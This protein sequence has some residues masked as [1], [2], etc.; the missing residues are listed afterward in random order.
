MKDLAPEVSECVAIVMIKESFL[1]YFIKDNLII[2]VL[3]RFFIVEFNCG[4]TTS[5]NSTYFANPQSPQRI[6]NLMINRLNNEICQVSIIMRQ[7]FFG[8]H[9][10][11]TFFHF[12][13]QIRID[14]E[15]FDISPPDF[16]GQCSTDFFLV[17]GGSPVPTLCGTNTGQHGD[18]QLFN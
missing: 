4:R 13:L 9:G 17:T 15:T 18:N 7:I 11:M 6:C 8:V 14:F 2:S 10:W 1:V 5:E 12:A 3:F 16:R